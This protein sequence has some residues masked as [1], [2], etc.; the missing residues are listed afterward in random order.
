M[1]TGRPTDVHR[2]RSSGPRHRHPRGLR[3]L[4][5]RHRLVRRG[6]TKERL[7]RQT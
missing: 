4:A 3:H 2:R 1:R 5:L 7:A 6:H